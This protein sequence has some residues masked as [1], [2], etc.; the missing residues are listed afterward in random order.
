MGGHLLSDAALI[1]VREVVRRVL[2][3]ASNGRGH[4]GVPPVR[5][6]DL[7][8]GV[9]AGD[10]AAA[11]NILTGATTATL[12]VYRGDGA[13]DLESAGYSI[14]LTNRSLDLAG[15]T[16]VYAIARRLNGEW[17]P[18]WIDCSPTNEKQLITVEDATSGTFTLALFGDPTAGIAH[19][20]A[21]SAVKSA[22]EA[23]AGIDDV[24][25]TG[26]PLGTDDVLVEFGGSLAN[27]QVPKLVADAS[28][29]GGSS[30]SVTVSIDTEGCCG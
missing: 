21:A 20:A 11:T 25:C 28:G 29:L 9:L 27:T 16:G 15:S 13:G 17:R 24:T 3:Q 5:E 7:R 8:E 14:E 1:Q 12:T 10:L 4:R 30:P 19:D 2:G 6:G 26:G 22:L 23:T 18:I